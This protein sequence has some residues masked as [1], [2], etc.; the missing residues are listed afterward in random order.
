MEPKPVLHGA[1][2]ELWAAV[3]VACVS[4]P[5]CMGIASMSGAPPAAGILSG[6]IGGLVVALLTASPTS[7]TGP[8]AGLTLILASQMSMLGSFD[9][10]LV[11]VVVAGIFQM[12]MGVA[13]LGWI[14]SYFPSSIL[15]SLLAAIG[16][17]LILKQVPHLLG[18]DTD[19]VGDMALLQ[20]DRHNTFSELYTL[21]SGEVHRGSMAVGLITLGFLIT[22]RH[23]KNQRWLPVPSL[24]LAILLGTVV[25]QLLSLLGGPWVIGNEHLLRLPIWSEEIPHSSIFTFPDW[26][27]LTNPLV[28]GAATWIALT[29]T[30]ET[31]LNV[32]VTDRLDNEDR[33]TPASREL[34]AQGA[35]NLLAGLLGGIPMSATIERSAISLYAGA[36][37]WYCAILYGVVL[38]IG[39]LVIPQVFNLIPLS[40]LAAVLIAVGYSLA[41][42]QVFI[43]VWREGKYQFIPFVVALFAILLSDLMIGIVIG[44][45]FAIGFILNSNLRRPLRR[46]VEKHVGGEILH[47]ELAEQVSFL[48]RPVIEKALREAPP[49]THILLDARNTDYIDHDILTMIRTFTDR[50]AAHD[51]TVSLRGFRQ[52]YDIEDKIQFVDFTSREVQEKLTPDEALRILQDGNERFCNDRRL[53]RDLGRMVQ[54]TAGGQFP[55]AAVLSCIDSR[56]PV[57]TIL[58]VGVGDV[59]SARVAGNVTSPKVLGSLEYATSVAG[60]KLILVLGHTRCGA[61][62]SA[63]QF[64]EDGKSGYEATGCHHLDSILQEIEPSINLAEYLMLNPSDAS[65]KNHFIEQVAHRNVIHSVRRIV[66]TSE[67]IRRLVDQGKVAVVGAIYDVNSGKIDFL[68]EQAIGLNR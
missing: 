17:I 30:L 32:S 2:N 44:L 22:V 53:S 4:I 9:A 67:S 33:V 1:L 18:H 14:A 49:G 8:S 29:S 45:C 55:F 56:A 23:W 57:E 28:F 54:A 52:Q 66:E 50:A 36:R 5:M 51:V 40:A 59:F 19:P 63:V 11:A 31:L 41:N 46:V 62:Y 42:P 26:K 47:I 10:F 24:L 7:I 12:A 43:A 16:I 39:A 35:G 48:N 15:Q 13:K 38:T 60:S 6:I 34:V 21:L 65:V 27:Q 68:R 3:V 25:S 61:V 37:T 20:P 58:D 64:A